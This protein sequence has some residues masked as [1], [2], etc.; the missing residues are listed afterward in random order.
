VLDVRAVLTGGAASVVVHGGGIAHCDATTAE[1]AAHELGDVSDAATQR[2]QVGGG[3]ARG[4]GEL[5]H[6]LFLGYVLQTYGGG[7]LGEEVVDLDKLV[8]RGCEVRVV[9]N[10]NE[11]RIGTPLARA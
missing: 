4:V 5:E 1:V 7:T 9:V 10:G 8:K 3:R 11:V 6:A 2:G